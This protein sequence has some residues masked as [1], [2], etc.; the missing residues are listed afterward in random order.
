MKEELFPMIDSL[1]EGIIAEF[2]R[3]ANPKG[4]ATPSKE[5]PGYYHRGGGYYSKQPDGEITHKSDRGTFRA[6]TSKEKAA[7][8]QTTAPPV[9]GKKPAPTK[10]VAQ[11]KD[12]QARASREKAALAKDK[13]QTAT[14]TPKPKA[15]PSGKISNKMEEDDA[16]FSKKKVQDKLKDVNNVISK[17][18]MN[19]DEKKVLLGIVGKALRGEEL[20]KAERKFAS[21]WVTFPATSDPKI[22]FRAEVS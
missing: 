6:L 2:I 10:T 16:F 17:L 13:K 4:K 19:K 18:P 22:Y 15:V 8:N 9:K 7:K 5:H 20:T 11:D 12:L 21:D 1:I 14:P 3:E